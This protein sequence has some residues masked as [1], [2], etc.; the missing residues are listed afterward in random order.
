MKKYYPRIV[1]QQIRAL[2]K[3]IGAIVVNGPKACG[4]T[5]SCKHAAMTI[6]SF[7]TENE[8]DLYSINPKQALIGNPPIL[9]DEWQNIPSVWDEI[10]DDIN[11]SQEYGKYLLT[12][13]VNTE[14]ETYHSG[15]GR[16]AGLKMYPMS[17]F[18]SKDS[19]GEVSIQDLFDNPGKDVFYKD[20]EKTLDDVAFFL[21]R[22][23]WPLAVIN[24]D[25][26]AS[27]RYPYAYLNGVIKLK[28]RK[29]ENYFPRPLV[30]QYLFRSYA[31]NISTES[32]LT[33]IRKDLVQAGELKA[34]DDETFSSYLTKANELYVIEDMMAWMP[35]L[36]SKTGIR[37]TPTRHF[38]DPSLAV[39]ALELTPEMLMHD[40]NLF[41][42][43]FEDLA[44]RD[45]RIYT[46]LYAPQVKHYRNYLDEEVDAILFG[47]H[48]SW[49]PVE[50]KLGGK[51]RTTEAIESLRKFR[52]SLDDTFQRKPS[53]MMV[54]TAIGPTFK[55]NDNIYV[56]PI[57]RLKN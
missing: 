11:D 1:D 31:R 43:L 20:S 19:S 36:R 34:I 30:A 51:E 14:S 18:E 16:F 12:G 35:N 5:E 32:S 28:S 52:D 49:A 17:L 50:I 21:C 48:D 7:S 57:T 29:K 40:L 23:G 4:K 42:L 24:P 37:S 38:V 8:I 54:L 6:H 15:I 25:K 41:G 3:S 26:E 53:F 39:A 10:R 45:L 27:L 44:V 46:P 13:S 55:T 56:V 33:T 2:Q 47:N 22:G 9:I